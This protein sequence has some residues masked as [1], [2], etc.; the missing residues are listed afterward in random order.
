MPKFLPIIAIAAM[1]LLASCGG[2]SCAEVICGSRQNCVN[3]RCYCWDGW[4]GNNCDDLAA[5]KYV[6][7]WQVTAGCQQGFVPAHISQ[8]NYDPNREDRIV[9]NNFLNRGLPL[10]VGIFTD[11]SNEG[12]LIQFANQQVGSLTVDGQGFFDP[13]NN[14]ISIDIQYSDFGS[15]GFCT[16]TYF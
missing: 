1:A 5:D 12:N 14:R 15:S 3:G 9:I 2:N 10:T 8:I 16:L 11:R 7:S 13:V 4:E 6:G